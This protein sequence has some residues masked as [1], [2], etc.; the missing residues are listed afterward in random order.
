MKKALLAIAAF[1]L[2]LTSCEESAT[3]GAGNFKSEREKL[4][5]SLGVDIG[6]N[7]EKAK[8]DSLDLEALYNGLKD[9]VNKGTLKMTDEECKKT[10]MDYFN[11]KQQA[12]RAEK[13]AQGQKF[14]V[15][16]AKKSGVVTLASGLQYQVVKEGNGPKP[17]INDKVTVHYHGTLLD[18]KVF[19]SS[20][21]SGKPITFPVGGV[22]TGWTEAL[23]LMPVGSKWKLFIP[24]NLAYGEVGAGG[25]IGPNETLVFEV[26]LLSISK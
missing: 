23:Q 24:S 4:S 22:I 10:I 8:I 15:E 25:I 16:N 2:I 11:K 17:T 7:V 1:G 12:E 20:I 13:V 19:D 18:G 5:Y 26:E 9:V 3:T 14:L 6:R 21:E